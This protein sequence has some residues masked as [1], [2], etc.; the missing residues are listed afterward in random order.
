MKKILAILL[1]VLLSNVLTAQIIEVKQDGTGDFTIIQEA[2]DASSAGNTVLVW[3]GTYFENVN[4]TGKN[5]TLASL[6]FTTGDE[7]YK[8]STIINGNQTG[9][10]MYVSMPGTTLTIYGFTLMN[11]SGN[12]EN[13]WN[14]GG[15]GI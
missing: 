10:C 14:Y 5:I 7:S 9:S 8:Y 13:Y 1:Y 12:I 6:A 15:G 3:P 2:V 11:G 4:L